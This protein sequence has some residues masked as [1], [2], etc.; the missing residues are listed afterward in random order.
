MATRVGEWHV[1]Q[2]L[3][4]KR[5]DM[6][7][8]AHFDEFERVP[9]QAHSSRRRWLP[10][11]RLRRPV[12][13]DAPIDSTHSAFEQLAHVSISHFTRASATNLVWACAAAAT[14]LSPVAGAAS[15]AV[16]RRRRWWRDR[17][18]RALSQQH[19]RVAE[20]CGRADECVLSSVR[21]DNVQEKAI[22]HRVHT[23][24]NHDVPW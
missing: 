24:L 22:A 11:P 23:V 7:K 2:V 14:K 12:D 1:Q 17:Q 21:V 5:L 6:I 10:P 16:P 8:R 9:R 20:T 3:A 15:S 4:N 18:E 19:V 13:A